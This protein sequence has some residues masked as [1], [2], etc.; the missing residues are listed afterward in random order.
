MTDN[1]EEIL[2]ELAEKV[3]ES[4][5]EL[6]ESLT[7]EVKA[8]TP[9]RTGALRD[10][11]TYNIQ[12]DAVEIGSPLDYAKYVEE[13]TSK[14]KAEHMVRDTMQDNTSEILQTIQEILEK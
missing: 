13:G 6:G 1:S 5:E 14:Q 4:L 9:V 7:E 3:E 8:R 12:G 10:S 11:M 2:Q